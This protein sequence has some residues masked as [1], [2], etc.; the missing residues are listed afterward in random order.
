MFGN[1]KKN[2]VI[3][4]LILL[5]A[6]LLFHR[7]LI[8]YNSM[9][10]VECE[11]AI[12]GIMAKHIMEN[13]YSQSIFDYT[14]P[15]ATG[16]FIITSLLALPFFALLG[17]STISLKCVALLFNAGTLIV[18]YLFLKRFFGYG[19]AVLACILYILA[20]AS[21]V[22]EGLYAHK[23]L[24]QANFFI[25]SILFLYFIISI[26]NGF[27][28][29]KSFIFWGLL[30]GFAAWH[31]ILSLIIVGVCLLSWF[32]FEKGFIFSRR[33]LY[34]ILSFL[35]GISPKIYYQ[36]TRG[37]HF[38]LSPADI[39]NDLSFK[40]LFAIAHRF[41]SIFTDKI[42]ASLRFLD[43]FKVSGSLQSGFYYSV[44]IFSY[45]Y[46]LWGNKAVIKRLIPVPLPR[47]G[48][49][50]EPGELKEIIILA[51]PLVYILLFS[52]TALSQNPTPRYMLPLYT[53]FFIIISI[54]LDKLFRAGAK[55][56]PVNLC[57][58]VFI[59]ACLIL[60]GLNTN[61]KLILAGDPYAADLKPLIN[62]FNKNKIKFVYVS[63]SERW[64]LLFESGEK[65]I[66]SS[67]DI[68]EVVP[69]DSKNRKEAIDDPSG[70][71]NYPEYDR[72]VDK[73]KDYAYAFRIE[74]DFGHD[75]IFKEYLQERDLQYSQEQ[76]KDFTVYWNFSKKI[77]PRDVG[78]DK[79]WERSG[80]GK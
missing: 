20:P 74:S 53:S 39:S 45:L 38:Y 49:A 46:I 78:F 48:S 56:R 10:N 51:F 21:F 6:L 28:G 1:L 29:S 79:R 3:Y 55:S 13:N 70:R 59:S 36:F 19:A 41:G 77:R 7:F 31:H 4:I 69:P 71:E 14:L 61:I 30:C 54:A 58:P 44:I 64:P 16:F 25:I 12:T 26:K 57:L 50:P 37:W 24:F 32:I 17:I 80:H 5:V 43:F 11:E 72:L 35:A 8:I 63:F 52:F 76:V 33:F 67:L 34:F 62:A 15:Y 2:R 47:R 66:T 22:Q 68:W 65:I 75:K 60:F 73:A 18:M 42:P 23:G 9:N 40:N 27:K